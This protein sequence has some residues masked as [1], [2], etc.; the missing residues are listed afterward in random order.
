MANVSNVNM[1]NVLTN[2]PND[3]TIALI[4]LMQEYEIR[5]DN[6]RR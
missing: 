4:R 5:R 6:R 2:W 1:F 3:A